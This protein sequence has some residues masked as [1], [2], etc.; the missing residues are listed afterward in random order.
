M[1]VT[2]EMGATSCHFEFAQSPRAYWVEIRYPY[3]CGLPVKQQIGAGIV[4]LADGR[5]RARHRE[6]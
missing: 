5:A 4:W 3:I 2:E 1:P 6:S